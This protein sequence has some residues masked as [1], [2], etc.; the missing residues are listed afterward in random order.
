[1]KNWN[2][3]SFP[4]WIKAWN[5]TALSWYILVEHLLEGILTWDQILKIILPTRNERFPLWIYI[6]LILKIIISHVFLKLKIVH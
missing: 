4:V 2:D 1:M 5:I 3:Y 6:N